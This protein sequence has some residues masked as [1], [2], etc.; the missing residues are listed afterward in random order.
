MP[1]K[2][3]SQSWTEL[4]QAGND[5]FRA[6]Q[7]GEAVNLYSQSIQLLDKSGKGSQM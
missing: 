6:G 5:S 4:K 7:Y 3:R 1:Q 2:R